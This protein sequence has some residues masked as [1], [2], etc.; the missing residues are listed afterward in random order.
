MRF[1]LVERFHKA[2]E[3]SLELLILLQGNL[4][5]GRAPRLQV[6]TVGS[7]AKMD[8]KQR[9]HNQRQPQP[10]AEVRACIQQHP[11]TGERSVDI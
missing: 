7:Q 3:S 5:P 11:Q 1:C 2:R 6:I 4:C 10:V 8:Q 9:A